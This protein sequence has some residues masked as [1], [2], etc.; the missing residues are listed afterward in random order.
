[1]WS[2]AAGVADVE[3]DEAMRPDSKFGIGSIPKAFVSVVV[4]LLVEEGVRSLDDTLSEETAAKFPG[5]DRITVRML[6][7]HTNGIPEWVSQT[8][9]EVTAVDPSTIWNIETV[10]DL[11]A[12]QAPAFPPGEGYLYSNT[13]Y[14]LLGMIIEL[15]PIFEGTVS[16]ITKMFLER[17][18]RTSA[19][20]GRC[21][22]APS[23]ESRSESAPS[24]S[25]AQA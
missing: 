1:M 7:N 4:L 12:A 20:T 18:C 21:A 14:T 15:V 24:R 2:G 11:A 19:R 25:S 16:A 3:T 9:V 10:R 17:I 23:L 6:L 13:D 22:A 5:S 8:T